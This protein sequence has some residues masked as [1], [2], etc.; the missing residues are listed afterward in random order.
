VEGLKNRSK[1]HILNAMH[2]DTTTTT[3]QLA[4]VL[5]ALQHLTL[6]LYKTNNLIFTER[7]PINKYKAYFRKSQQEPTTK[8]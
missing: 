4:A 1:N 2:T 6:T 5:D 8:Q 3:T 7:K